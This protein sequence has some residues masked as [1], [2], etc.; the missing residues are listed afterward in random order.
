MTSCNIDWLTLSCLTSKNIHLDELLERVLN[1]LFLNKIWDNF[2]YVG[3]DKYYAAVYRY[4]DISICLCRDTSEQLIKQGIAVKFSGN[5]L[6]YY[7]EYLADKVK[8]DLRTACKRW[9]S[10]CCDGFFTRCTRFDFAA[11]DKQYNDDKPYLTMSRVRQ[12]CARREVT[13]RLIVQRKPRAQKLD[14]SFDDSE[15][16]GAL[17]GDTVY[18]GKRKGANTLVR[19]YDK[20]LETKAHKQ[21]I[22]D[23]LTSWCRCEIEFHNAR[24]M[25]AFNAFCDKSDEE[26][27][28]Y[29]AEVINNYVSFI[30]RDN[31]NTSR[32]T[33]KRW[34]SQFL[35]T[36]EKSS[37]VSPPYKPATF[38]GTQKWLEK[39]VFP[40]LARFVQ[41]IG[42]DKF[43]KKLG[44]YLHEEPSP[45]IKQMLCDYSTIKSS[46][47]KLLVKDKI[48]Y[49]DYLKARGFD[50]WL[51]TGEVSV[52]DLKADFADF[53]DFSPS[54]LSF[55]GIPLTLACGEGFF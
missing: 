3:R 49:E 28:T 46:S 2:E 44:G 33:I 50:P 4:N 1:C 54:A 19:F 5:G 38:T 31:S 42:L 16:C 40:T 34:W 32:C 29:M 18:F 6:A 45:R 30:Y 52:Q 17:V 48:S 26:F 24:S 37:L 21:T 39:S 9:R 51:F 15:K 8:K 35:G 47:S 20:M 53:N 13:S 23:N 41:C 55:D 14:I 11:D 25:A 10:L 43:L 22:E 7:Q 27:N 12:S 36:V